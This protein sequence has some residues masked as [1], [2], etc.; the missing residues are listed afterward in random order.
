[1]AEDR[2]ADQISKGRQAA[3]VIEPLRLAAES[4][5]ASLTKFLLT[6][7]E[8]EMANTRRL[9]KATDG[10]V[11]ELEQIVADGDM[12]EH[13]LKLIEAGRHKIFNVA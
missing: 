3:A 12:A 11:R 4:F 7:P 13:Q 6:C 2:L 10:V 1:M 9:I 8:G 5:K